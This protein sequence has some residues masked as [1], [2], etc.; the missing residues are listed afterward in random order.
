MLFEG[1]VI[2]FAILMLIFGAGSLPGEVY[3]P[4]VGLWLLSGSAFVWWFDRHLRGR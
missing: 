4:V 3:L 1:G 2:A